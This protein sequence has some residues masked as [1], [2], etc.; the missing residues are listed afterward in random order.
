LLGFGV[1]GMFAAF[2]VGMTYQT[3]TDYFKPNFEKVCALQREFSSLSDSFEKFF[4]PAKVFFC[5]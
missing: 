4:F 2:A 5:I 3:F 1:P